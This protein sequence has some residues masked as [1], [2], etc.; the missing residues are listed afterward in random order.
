MAFIHGK[1]ASV[2]HGVYNLSSYF[3]NASFSGSVETG[4][5]T[6]FGAGSKTY[7]AGLKDGTVSVSGLFDGASGAVDEVLAAALGTEDVPTVVCPEGAGTLGNRAL[8]LAAD[9]TSYEVTTPVADVV[10]TSA[11]FQASGGVNTGVVLSPLSA[12]SSTVTES[13]VDNGASTSNGAIVMV[14]VTANTRN[15]TVTIKTQHSSDNVTFVDLTTTSVTGSTTTSA[16]AT[17]TGT[18]NRYL[19]S[20]ITVAGST[21]SITSMTSVAR[22]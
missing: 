20:N 13:S 10:S 19:R 14:N 5:T 11:E 8:M 15:G 2:I 4:E 3:N 16:R 12:R 18:V 1:S 21:G 22:G 9:A 6:T 7:V 17:T